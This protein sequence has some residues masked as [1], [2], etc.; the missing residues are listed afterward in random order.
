MQPPSG[1]LVRTQSPSPK[2]RAPCLLTHA[3]PLREPTGRYPGCIR[4]QHSASVSWAPRPA[5]PQRA[6]SGLE[7]KGGDH[8][9]YCIPDGVG[10]GR[11]G[12]ELGAR[13]RLLPASATGAAVLDQQCRTQP[14][15]LQNE[16]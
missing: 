3:A 8:V 14:P 11:L 9:S 4:Q 13:R 5:A 12:E 10:P 2:G 1:E 15:L 6:Q 16:R 7:L